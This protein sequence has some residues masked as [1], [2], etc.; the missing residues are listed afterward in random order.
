MISAPELEP[1]RTV[2]VAAEVLKLASVDPVR[3]DAPGK[4]LARVA[5]SA[6]QLDVFAASA[7]EAVRSVELAPA[8]NAAAT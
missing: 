1:V 7:P 8:C 6:P 3:L 2:E 4:P 5:G